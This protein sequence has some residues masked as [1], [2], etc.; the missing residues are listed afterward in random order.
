MS[1]EQTKRR[2][3]KCDR[4]TERLIRFVAPDNTLELVCW[5]CVSR[6]EKRF[7]LNPTWKR[8]GRTR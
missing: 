1:E 4:E 8:G 2:C 6:E 7:N 3:E 5:S